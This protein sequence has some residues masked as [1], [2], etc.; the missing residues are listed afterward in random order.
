MNFGQLRTAVAAE[1]GLAATSDGTGNEQTQVD[2]A[3]N[4]AVQRVLEDTRCYVVRTDFSSFDGTDDDWDLSNSGILDVVELY[5]TSSGG[6]RYTLERVSVTDIIEKRRTGVPSN[7]PVSAYAVSGLNLI[8]FWPPPSSTDVLSVYNVPTPTALASAGDDPSLT[9]FAG[10]PEILHE[11]IFLYAC[12]RAASYDDDQ[13]SAQ[14]Q[15]YLTLYTAEIARYQKIERRRGGA[16]NARARV[17]EKR[18][19]R[20]FH[21]NSVY[22]Q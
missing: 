15:R 18:I 9:A 8:M 21:D 16:R 7:S 19:R 4:R 20:P 22:P 2:D 11:A 10:I 6:T 12:A 5:L 1:V 17:N 13:S 14:G 3:I